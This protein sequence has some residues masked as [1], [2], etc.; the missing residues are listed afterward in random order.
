[1]LHES[2]FWLTTVEQPPFPETPLPQKVDVAVIGGGF[3]GLSAARSLA[4]AG[5]SVGVLE[6]E[7]MGW[8]ASCRNGG[9][10]LSGMKLGTET[11]IKKYG[12]ARARRMFEMSLAS[13]STVE[14]LIREEAIEC[15]FNR[16]GHLEVAWKPGHY[17]GFM[18]A[19]ELVEKEFGH[20]LRP[21][22]KAELGD[23][24]GSSLYH[25]GLVD[26][27]S[28]GLNPAQ[29]VMGLAKA[30]T[31]AGA[32]MFEHTRVRSVE[33]REG[34]F[35]VRTSRG[36]VAA[37]RVF[38]ATSGY[39][40]N[41]TPSLRRRIIPIGS[42]IIATEPLAPELARE[43]SPR[44]RMIFDS[45]NFL[46]Y[47][48]LTPDNRM[49]FGGRA[50]FT[51]ETPDSTRKS[52]EILR[53]GMLKVYPQLRDSAVE[54]VWGGTLDFAYDIMPHTGTLDGLYYS[55]G[56][57][58]HGVAF[59]TH[60]GQTVARQMLGEQVENPL[61]GLPFPQVPLY[62]GNP[63]LHLPVAGLYYRILDWVS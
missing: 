43:V 15:S 28:G 38:V 2:N 30:A 17:D 12:R 36:A 45:K 48:R 31:G 34:K 44:K 41:A 25:G 49:L 4:Q 22:P 59:A 46:Y 33:G 1:M 21:V 53:Q 52:A 39:T 50:A 26:E 8:G 40:Q 6:A 32:C 20:S 13:I 11:L 51:P 42:Y 27:V 16:C 5:A 54:Y 61:D 58:G 60:L 35:L 19:A 47:F 7:T 29:Y 10:V 55:L 18:R 57:A 3:S 62:S 9:M 24:I 23:E 56:Y 37:D 63:V 14:Q